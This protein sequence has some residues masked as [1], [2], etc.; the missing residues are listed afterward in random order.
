MATAAQIKLLTSQ[1]HSISETVFGTPSTRGE[2]ELRGGRGGPPQ[3]SD[4]Q[5]EDGVADE[6]VEILFT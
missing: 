6:D 4:D 2:G 5:V 1:A 3:A